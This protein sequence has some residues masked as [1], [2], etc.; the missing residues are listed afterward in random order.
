MAAQE[1]STALVVLPTGEAIMRDVGDQDLAL[2]LDR[3][4]QL[5]QEL[6]DA[7]A[8][9]ERAVVARMDRAGKWSGKRWT[10]RAGAVALQLKS[11]S[12]T[13]GTTGHD[14]HKLKD[15]L[16]PLVDAGVIDR[17][18][19]DEAVRRSVSITFDGSKPRLEQFAEQQGAKVSDSL[20][21]MKG[22]LG[23]LEA[24]NDDRVNAA[25]EAAKTVTPQ[26]KRKVTLK[27]E[28]KDP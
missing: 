20:S 24:L 13:A 23:A 4:A 11:T 28:R 14:A 12:P 26:G 3:I 27:V 2:G 18:L 17:E 22:A 21:V 15:G 5:E 10:F 7:R 6:K 16:V 19:L 9:V 1:E 8:E 25:L